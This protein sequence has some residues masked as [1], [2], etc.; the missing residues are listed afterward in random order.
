MRQ[1]AAKLGQALTLPGYPQ[2]YT[3]VIH[4][5]CGYPRGEGR[6]SATCRGKR[7]SIWIHTTKMQAKRSLGADYLT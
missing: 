5:K 4:R 3:Q 1:N 2:V 7:I 6:R